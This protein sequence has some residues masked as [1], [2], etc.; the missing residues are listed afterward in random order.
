MGGV[1]IAVWLRSLGLE[2]YEPA[3]RDNDIEAQTLPQLTAEDLMA[4]GI[5]SIGH[6]RRLL[7]AI[8]A[9]REAPAGG[10]L[11]QM[12]EPS[13]AERRQL[14][15]VF[16]DLVGSTELSQ[17]LDPEQMRDVI[18]CLPECSVGGDCPIRGLCR[19]AHG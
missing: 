6:R 13:R 1:D 8:A 3:F 11:K 19:Q 14:T 18:P 16:I 12:A 2:H 7:T 4:L 15:V 10:A 5:S 9:L 17:R